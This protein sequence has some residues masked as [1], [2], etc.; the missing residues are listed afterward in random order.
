MR[1]TNQMPTKSRH[2]KKTT[3][4]N[5]LSCCSRESRARRWRDAF[6]RVLP[7]TGDQSNRILRWLVDFYKGLSA[8]RSKRP[9][10]LRLWTPAYAIAE[11]LEQRVLLAADFGD[12]PD[13]G[14]GTGQGD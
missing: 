8:S 5:R 13:L 12:A 14:A 2:R 4:S 11:L 7:L 1:G 3:S 9:A 6:P 10:S